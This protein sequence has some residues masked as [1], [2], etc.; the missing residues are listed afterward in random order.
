MGYLNPPP[1]K[2]KAS[3]AVRFFFLGSGHFSFGD[4]YNLGYDTVK[5]L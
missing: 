1:K 4:L 2:T 5:I 3:V